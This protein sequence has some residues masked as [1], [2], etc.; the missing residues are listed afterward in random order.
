MWSLRHSPLQLAVSSHLASISRGGSV[1]MRLGG[2]PNETFL[3]LASITGTAPGI[4]LG[5]GL[6]LPL[7]IDGWFNNMLANPGAGVVEGA[8]GT[9][10]PDGTASAQF[11]V[12]T[13]LDPALMGL[14]IWHA[15][16]SLDL[17]AASNS[18]PITLTP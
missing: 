11:T 14:T 6:E 2:D 7:V 1:E 18:I 10:G 5:S 17:R 4:P 3:I 15:W 12:P 8:L 9:L 16:A 13:G